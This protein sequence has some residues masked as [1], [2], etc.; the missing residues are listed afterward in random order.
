MVYEF[1]FNDTEVWDVIDALKM[2]RTESA[3]MV[4]G[5]EMTNRCLA[6]EKKMTKE[7]TEKV[8]GKE[9]R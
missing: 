9:V 2:M 7:V 3:K 4:W 8:M 5:E 6:L 1:K